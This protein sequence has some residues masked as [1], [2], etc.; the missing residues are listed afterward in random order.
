M[1]IKT[2]TYGLVFITF[3]TFVII[4]FQY[5]TDVRHLRVSM[6]QSH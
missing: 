5:H 4:T 3:Y 6:S 1:E 2:L